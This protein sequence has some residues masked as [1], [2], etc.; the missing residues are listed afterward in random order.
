M[1]GNHKRDVRILRDLVKQYVDLACKPIQEER[2][3][4]WSDLLSLRR[5][6]PLVLATYGMW[7]VWCREVFGDN[8]LKCEDPLLRAHER[9]L[10]MAIF[11]DPIGDDFILEPWIGE[12]AVKDGAW[13]RLFGVE[14][15]LT[16]K[17]AEGG[18]GAYMPVLKDWSDMAK[19]KPVRHRIDEEATVRK[20]G[21]LKEAIGDLVE[22]DVNRGPVYSGFMADIS[23]NLATLRGLEQ[24]MVDM[25]ESPRQLHALAAFIRDATL[26]AQ[27]AAEAAGDY[28]LNCH[29]MQEMPY[30]RDLEW[31]RPNVRPRLRRDLWCFCAAQEFTLISPKMHDEFLLRYQMPIIRRFGLAA[32]GCCEDLTRKIDMLRQVPNLR[33]IAVTPRADVRRCA[34]EIGTDYVIS[35]RPNPADMVCCGFDEG[36]IGRI[37]RE[38]MEA[39]MGLHVCIHLKDIE[40]VEGDPSRLARWV[41]IV[42]RIGDEYA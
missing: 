33:L 29:G 37:I 15:R 13:G 4:L 38:G 34:Q 16:D 21:A 8:T 20:V 14:Q 41:R 42:R 25:Y 1:S 26:A 27:D 7:N 2:R 36:K 6:R 39:C 9:N 30:S 5:T 3:Q 10:R 31:P 11:H 12:E 35:W 24:M 23:W 18:A 28:G 32:Y 19:L 40:T 17:P 22:I